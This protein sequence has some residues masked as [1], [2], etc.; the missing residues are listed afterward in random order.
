MALELIRPVRT[1]P[2][3]GELAA[4]PFATWGNPGIDRN[5][6]LISCSAGYSNILLRTVCLLELSAPV[7]FGFLFK[8]T[9]WIRRAAKS[10]EI[11][12]PRQGLCY[13]LRLV[14]VCGKN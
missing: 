12:D 14:I 4:P 10:T 8:S 9:T 3:Q 2:S 1:R 7:F 6:S 11:F 5:F 13:L